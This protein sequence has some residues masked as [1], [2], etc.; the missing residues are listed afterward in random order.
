MEEFDDEEGGGLAQMNREQ[1]TALYEQSSQ[2]VVQK[3]QQEP[4]YPTTDKPLA[5]LGRD[6]LE[7]AYYSH[8]QR[9]D[10]ILAP[11]REKVAKDFPT[12]SR[13]T[14]VLAPVRDII[15]GF[16]YRRS[17][18]ALAEDRADDTDLRNI[19]IYEQEHQRRQE[20]ER[21]LGGFVAA[22]AL[23]LPLQVGSLLAGGAAAAPIKGTG[24]GAGAARLG[25]Q[26]LATPTMWAEKAMQINTEQGR[27]PYDLRGLP[28]PAA[29]GALQLGV[30]NV[31]A[32]LAG[33]AFPGEGVKQLAGRAAVGAVGQP[34]EQAVTDPFIGAAEAVV[35]Q[36]AP[37]WVQRESHYGAFVDLING[38]K[39]EALR[40]VISQAMIGASFAFSHGKPEVAK[41]IEETTQRTLDQS[42]KG[43]LSPEA[44]A[45]KVADTLADLT[46]IGLQ[47]A[48]TRNHYDLTLAGKPIGQ[49]GFGEAQPIPT[50][51]AADAYQ[52]M[53]ND[54][55][56]VAS[57][58]PQVKPGETVARITGV[59]LEAPYRGQGLGQKVYLASMLQHGADWYY[60][61][62]GTPA[63]A[64]VYRALEAKG[65]I[66]VHWE[67][68]K[69]P[70]AGQ[71]AGTRIVRLTP[72]GIKAA[73]EI[74]V[75]SGGMPSDAI[76]PPV[77]RPAPETT[78]RPSEAVQRAPEQAGATVPA[79]E[80]PVTLPAEVKAGQK[81][82]EPTVPPGTAER[83]RFLGPQE[84]AAQ[85]ARSRGL[86]EEAVAYMREE[87]QLG[88]I[89]ET[90]GFFDAQKKTPRNQT[91][92]RAIE[93]LKDND[94][95]AA[96]ADIDLVNL[97]GLN[98]SMGGNA[99]G[100]VVF[101]KFADVIKQEVEK[102]G[103]DLVFMRHGGDEMSVVAVGVGPDA[104]RE[105]L[106]RAQRITS[107]MGREIKTVK[108][109]KGQPAGTPLAEIKHKVES[110]TENPK[111]PGVGIQFGVAEI[112]KSGD[113]AKIIDDAESQTAKAKVER[114]RE[115]ARR[116]AQPGDR[117]P[118]RRADDV[119]KPADDQGRGQGA[120]R[121][122]EPTVPPGTPEQLR[123]ITKTTPEALLSEAKNHPDITEREL[124]ILQGRL[125]DENGN[126][127]SFDAIGQD[128][129]RAGYK[130]LTGPRVKQIEGKILEKLGYE[131]TTEQLVQGQSE[132]A[133][134][135]ERLSRAGKHRESQEPV[136]YE[137]FDEFG[138]PLAEQE[139]FS[140]RG[141][142]PQA[143]EAPP[144]PREQLALANESVARNR[145][146]AQRAPLPELPEDIRK[147]DPVL[148]EQ[149]RTR[150]QERPSADA[151]VVSDV[152]KNPRPVTDVED[153]LILRR[154]TALRNESDRIA[155]E[156]GREFRK[157]RGERDEAKLDALEQSEAELSDQIDLADQA[158]KVSGREW[159]RS[160]RARQLLMKRDFTRA[161]I[162]ARTRRG[163]G[164][165]L[166]EAETARLTELAEKVQSLEEKLAESREKW[167]LALAD[168][169][170]ARA[171]K[172]VA[173]AT[174][175][176]TVPPG[177]PAPKAAPPSQK[178]S[179][180]AKAEFDSAWA[181]F[182][183][184]AGGLY[185][186]PL[187]PQIYA[188]MVKVAGKAIKLG[189]AKVSDFV[190]EI[191]SRSAKWSDQHEEAVTK[192]FAQAQEEARQVT[193]DDRLG[194][195]D[196]NNPRS[197]SR[198]AQALAKEFVAQ[199]LTDR[200]A[201]IDAV[202][203]EL[204]SIAPDLTRREAMDAISGYGDF[205]PL[206]Q[207]EVSVK[208]RDLK[209][210][211]QQVGKIEDMQAGQAP[212]KTGPERRAP[213]DT[214]RALIQQ[215]NDLKK[216]LGI[217]TT[218]PATQLK[219]TLDASKTRMRNQIEDL[220]D[221]IAKGEQR[222]REKGTGPTDAELD[223]LRRIRDRLKTDF[224]NAFG[225]PELT[226]E[227]RVKIATEAVQRSIDEYE[228]RI[229]DKDFAR[230][231]GL[232]VSTPELDA[233]KA[234]RDALS[235][236]FQALRDA[237]P[238]VQAEQRDAALRNR[239]ADLL[240]QVAEL[241]GQL[242]R[243]EFPEKTTKDKVRD[244]ETDRLEF[245]R[246]QARK[247]I[248]REIEKVKESQQGVVMKALRFTG[249]TVD[250][251]RAMM[252]GG[253][254]FP[255]LRQEMT[256]LLSHPVVTIKSNLKSLRSTVS[257]FGAHQ[258]LKEV[259]ERE[260][261]KNGL[262]KRA[263]NL[264]LSDVHGTNEFMRSSWIQYVPGFA[265]LD[266]LTST[267][268]TRLRADLFDVGV[269]SLSRTGTPTEAEARG[270]GNAVNILTG[271]ANLGKMEGAIGYLNNAFLAP[272]WRISR[273][274]ALV[275][276]P[277][278]MAPGRAKKYVAMEYARMV[279]GGLLLYGLAKMAAA[280]T[281]TEMTIETDS[282]SSD[283]M[284]FRL[285]K[286]RLNPLAGLQQVITFA[287][288]MATGEKKVGNKV[289]NTDMMRELGSYTRNALAPVPGT[290]WNAADIHHKK[291]Q[292]GRP[293]TYG[294]LALS[295]VLP[296]S[297]DDTIEAVKELGWPAGLAVG[298]WSAL[299]GGAEVYDAKKNRR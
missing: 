273:M 234:R 265:G 189:V 166:D 34:I 146:M 92:D 97:G 64:N 117:S 297:L 191:R 259:A 137:L 139:K 102:A 96:Y 112:G 77:P 86:S 165:A 203:G 210:Q 266:R 15:T 241:K 57:I 269:A 100:D 106:G 140:L 201:V 249:K 58:F 147:S 41:Q 56:T 122:G 171:K 104:L 121:P 164:K 72:E 215:V 293:T 144:R 66:E 93:F 281:D 194:R 294:E 198:A 123:P 272:S 204:R 46:G 285:G 59:E 20:S 228:Q 250:L 109:W 111:A 187:D 235:E 42:A 208:L 136:E 143:G 219:S 155:H 205:R 24:L 116:K 270:I 2:Q 43:G 115:Y 185:A 4:F 268:L 267:S 180:K 220:A 184:A 169:E 286:L 31:T 263:L 28:V 74:L 207:D 217:Q 222:R 79:P 190:T 246:D 275:G 152:L 227:Q 176:P 277:V 71:T 118:G 45:P 13:L 261:A 126:V 232:A 95:P 119:A 84:F 167:S 299:G 296:L 212:L 179:T 214:E 10:Q 223:L 90:T 142:Q 287:S 1:L 80:S 85:K 127:M 60:N 290:A 182:T 23:E 132:G 135:Q 175:P 105:A 225:K 29:L 133:A 254:L 221:Q 151:D 32:A 240:A 70:Q 245:E 83:K 161:G 262:Y 172:D 295:T 26:T 233:L 218:D 48:E 8:Q 19:T 242:A 247:Q 158:A 21:S 159:G 183:K 168:L 69:G 243:G 170:I 51:E 145:E 75:K 251:M 209:G 149:M 196:A 188:A 55:V 16:A 154:Q 35:R 25:A 14:Q 239:K 131:G 9:E 37:S 54:A 162:L 39:G 224:D 229:K 108:E 124:F 36:V 110:T 177:T 113:R 258:V 128:M 213:T 283:F 284:E 78:Q 98:E 257:K 278:W 7:H 18:Q 178:W 89:D 195:V 125:P 148:W 3:A 153:L 216:Q 94:T 44:A 274:E 114:G 236:E 22:R 130:P 279:T 231:R 282:R 244:A 30:L 5:G 61:T 181:D 256:G 62:Q 298:L 252:L 230:R 160:G 63:A 65:L 49:M 173:T 253:D 211:M 271:R 291:V 76:K 138:R 47:P 264:D 289:Q 120:Q 52:G 134:L 50:K 107:E 103:G 197:L 6:E 238:A 237:D 260:N 53:P 73:E 141:G 40:Q 186:N 99:R 193:R 150:L 200:D 38:K 157:P 81:A 226:D 156:Y 174:E 11:V 192:A 276:L 288:R 68:G 163:K 206:S 101:R 88:S 91:L 17:K 27:E 199:G 33:K 202:H 129:E 82:A 87:G 67:G 248:Q 280:A 292:P 12:T 255:L